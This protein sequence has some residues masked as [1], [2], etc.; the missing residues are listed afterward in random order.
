MPKT[1]RTWDL[2]QA[3]DRKLDTH[4]EALATLRVESSHAK[5]LVAEMR[6]K[7]DEIEKRV[8]KVKLTIARWGGVAAAL[9]GVSEFFFH[10]VK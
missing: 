3:I 7:G 1:D 2:L 5:E 10:L 6:A 8:D 4:S 9:V